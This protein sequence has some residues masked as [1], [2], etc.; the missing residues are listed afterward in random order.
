MRKH[1]NWT[2]VMLGARMHYAVPKA[3][4]RIKKLKLFITDFYYPSSSF[5]KFFL[6]RKATTRYDKELPNT[7]VTSL[8]SLALVILFIRKFFKHDL[9]STHYSYLV[10]RL[11]TLIFSFKLPTESNFYLY[12]GAALE[13]LNKKKK[14]SVYVYEQMIATKYTERSIIDKFV[15]EHPEFGL[16]SNKK[17]AKYLKF[18]KRNITELQ[19]ADWIIVPSQFVYDDVTQ[20]VDKT[21]VKLIPYGYTPKKITKISKH[22]L[23]KV[24]TIGQ[25]GV[26][27]GSPIV[28]EVARMFPDLTF[29]M[30]GPIDLPETL[31]KS[32]PI[33][34]ILHGAVP[35]DQITNFYCDCDLFL[36]PSLCEGSATVIYEA[37]SYGLPILCSYNSGSV[38]RHDIEGF[39]LDSF[40]PKDY[41]CHLE[42]F[43]TDPNLIGTLSRNALATSELFNEEL[44]SG[45]LTKFLESITVPEIKS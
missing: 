10:N 33:N 22:R 8:N 20:Y 17:A 9:A 45:K 5:Y 38:V 25:V 34:V 18:Q 43:V 42:K 15:S 39:V 40:D 4:I 7:S 26:R 3:L 2:V 6:P 24:L 32:K 28:W 21:K 36:L 37:L 44:Y 41:A 30:V 12:H 23:S 11:Y 19:L 16:S 14:G 29:D 13:I 31:L 35:R 1:K 27:K